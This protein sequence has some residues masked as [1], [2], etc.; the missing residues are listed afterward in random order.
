MKALLEIVKQ[1]KDEVK[2]L[3]Q[4]YAK[5]PLATASASGWSHHGGG[6]GFQGGASSEKAIPD[7]DRKL[8]PTPEKYSGADLVKFVTWQEELKAYLEM[9]DSR[10]GVVLEKIEKGTV[11]ID[12]QAGLDIALSFG[13]VNTKEA[14]DRNLVG[15]FKTFTSGEAF[16]LITR[17]GKVASTR[18]TGSSAKLADP[19]GRSTSQGCACECSSRGKEFF[20]RS[21]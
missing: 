16:K 15:Y 21:S 13:I 17:M 7:M 8:V 6:G 3:K 1:L 18:P 2:E 12:A 11:A 19:G 10:F 20:S 4:N 5:P 14:L 9:Q